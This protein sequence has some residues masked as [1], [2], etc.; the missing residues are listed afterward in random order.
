MI[1]MIMMMLKTMTIIT[2]L[3][4][5]LSVMYKQPHVRNGHGVTIHK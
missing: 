5:M 1:M 4:T 3:K 2:G